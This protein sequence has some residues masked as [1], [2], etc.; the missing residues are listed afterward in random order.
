MKLILFCFSVM[1]ISYCTHKHTPPPVS[2][3]NCKDYSATY[4]YKSGDNGLLVKVLINGVKRGIGV[5]NFSDHIDFSNIQ[6]NPLNGYITAGVPSDTLYYHA[7]L[8]DSCLVQTLTKSSF[9]KVYPLIDTIS[10]T[11]TPATRLLIDTASVYT[12][13]NYSVH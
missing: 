6:F 13:L 11:T 1:L 12:I 10:I 8:N 2:L 9:Y 5:T 4:V 7:Y 3:G